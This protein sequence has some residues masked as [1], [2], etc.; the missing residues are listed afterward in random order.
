MNV[1]R[2]RLNVLQRGVGQYAVA[3]IEDVSRTPGGAAQH[4]VRGAEHAFHRREQQRRIEVPL[5][6]AV[7][8]DHGPGLVEPLA[9]V[10]A[11]HVPAGV[12][13]VR[14]DRAGPDPEVNR[15]DTGVRE[16]VE[17]LLRVGQR[18]LAVVGARQ[19]S[20]PGIENLHGLHARLDLRAHVVGDDGGEP[21]AEPVPRLR[22]RIHERLRRRV[23]RR[24]PA[25]D[26]IGGQRERRAAEAD[27]RNPAGER[28]PEQPD[29]RQ[30]VRQAVTRLDDADA[31]DV[32]RVPNRRRDGRPF[33]L[34]EIEGEP[35]RREG[36]QEVG[37]QDRR[38]DVD[39]LDGLQRDG[40]GELRLAADL[41]QGIAFAQRAVLR[42][43]SPRL[44]HEPDR[45]G[46]DGL[47]SAGAQEAIVHDEI[48]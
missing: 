12:L 31:I 45:R 41:E 32:G 22:L 17:N 34:D 36:Q 2:E 30:H 15:R 18:E 46:I 6:G 37:K 24:R 23:V 42:H 11:N 8:A 29:G 19:L 48:T 7:V 44:A 20:D 28:R 25:F 26:R 40:H 5:D 4:V 39:R 3:E 43:V 16:R 38:V 27:E 14:Q 21:V 9:P 33:P 10:H 1:S 35:H 13:H 47:S